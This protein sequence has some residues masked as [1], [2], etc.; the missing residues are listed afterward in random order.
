M[1]FLYELAS[2]AK[3]LGVPYRGWHAIPANILGVSMTELEMGIH[4]ID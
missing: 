4:F 2:P 1:G 3:L